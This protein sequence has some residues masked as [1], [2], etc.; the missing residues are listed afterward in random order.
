MTLHKSA[1]PQKRSSFLPYSE[2]TST[3]VEPL[4][5]LQPSLDKSPLLR[6][7][8][9]RPPLGTFGKVLAQSPGFPRGQCAPYPVGARKSRRPVSLWEMLW[10]MPSKANLGVFDPVLHSLVSRAQQQDAAAAAELLE[11]FQPLLR[12]VAS[13]YRHLSYEDALQEAHVAFLEGIA[14]YQRDLQIPFPGY[15]QRK[16]QGDV[17]SAMRREI[18]HRDRQLLPKPKAD[19]TE[20]EAD[21]WDAQAAVAPSAY[22]DVDVK[23][24]L[25]SV[26]LSP[27]ERLGVQSVLAGWSRSDV[28]EALNVSVESVKTWRKRA[29]RKLRES[30][31]TF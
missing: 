10:K 11:L 24:W 9:N 14:A 31:R 12:R 1:V 7:N 16:V 26:A 6:S 2:C 13:R 29:L 22:S 21:L 18:R 4:R 25:D 27:R 20:P 30:I 19:E 15:I 23:L 8:V 17:R 5:H 28:A 3:N